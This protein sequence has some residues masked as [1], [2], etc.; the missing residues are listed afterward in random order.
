MGCEGNTQKREEILIGNVE[1][2]LQNKDNFADKP[3][4]IKGNKRGLSGCEWLRKMAG[5]DLLRQIRKQVLSLDCCS[6]WF[7]FKQS[8]VWLF[9]LLHNSKVATNRTEKSCFDYVQEQQIFLLPKN[10]HK[11]FGAHPAFSVLDA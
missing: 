3:E 11:H 9:I 10:V 2:K 1:G 7:A 8:V 5:D 4:V 6:R